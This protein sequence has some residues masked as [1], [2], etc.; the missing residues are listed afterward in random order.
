MAAQA[1][2]RASRVVLTTG[3]AAARFYTCNP[4][5]FDGLSHPT[6][7]R[8][9]LHRVEYVMRACDI[10]REEWIVLAASLLEGNALIFWQALDED[11][12]AEIQWEDFC[13]MLKHQFLPQVMPSES[14]PQQSGETQSQVSVAVT[15]TQAREFIIQAERASM[16]SDEAVVAYIARVLTEVLAP[17]RTFNLSEDER[18]Q[19]LWRGLTE[20]YQRRLVPRSDQTLTQFI[21]EAKHCEHQ[22]LEERTRPTVV[23]RDFP[24]SNTRIR[25]HDAE[26]TT[27]RQR[28]RPEIEAADEP[29]AVRRRWTY[30]GTIGEEAS[31]N[32]LSDPEEDSEEDPEEDPED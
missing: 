14:A 11:E 1:A 13:H 28:L 2:H 32:P 3:R 12:I 7:I 8:D 27:S 20:E 31:G 29:M 17:N 25:R 10:A 16:R 23:R 15:Y 4:P 26:T 5:S 19:I 9:W 21:V 6:R 24:F 22:L 18:C 30:V